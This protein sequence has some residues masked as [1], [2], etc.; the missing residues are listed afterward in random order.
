MLTG[1]FNSAVVVLPENFHSAVVVLPSNFHSAVVVL[2]GN[3]HSAVVVLPGNFYSAVVVLSLCS[4]QPLS[5]MLLIYCHRDSY[6]YLKR[7][8]DEYKT[9][10]HILVYNIYNIYIYI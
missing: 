6:L 9:S 1:N 7:Y 5:F 2:P 3:F 4:R 10:R 8:T